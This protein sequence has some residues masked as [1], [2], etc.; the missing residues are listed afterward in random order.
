VLVYLHQRHQRKQRLEDK[1]DPHKSLDFGMDGV[2]VDGKPESKWAKQRKGPEMKVTEAGDMKTNRKDRG[3]SL[4]DMGLG[5]PYLLPQEVNGDGGSVR[6]MSRSLHDDHDPYGPV[7]FAKGDGE[8]IR[9]RAFNEKGSIYSAATSN[10]STERVGLVANASRMSQSYPKRG[11]SKLSNEPLSPQDSI[12]SDTSL[13]R[14]MTEHF[15][16]RTSYQCPLSSAAAGEG[17]P[18]TASSHLFCRR[19]T[20]L[21]KGFIAP[22]CYPTT[23]VDSVQR[24]RR[25]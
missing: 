9:S 17:G 8:S 5:N 19:W 7:T 11:D 18:S 3:L 1:N 25:H 14:H 21:Q 16:K 24:L 2:G 12:D 22:H 13:A 23:H 20:R 6:S 15:R 4:D 10:R